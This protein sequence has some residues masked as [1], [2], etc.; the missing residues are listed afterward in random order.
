[1]QMYA[2]MKPRSNKDAAAN[3]R[4]ALN[5]LCGVVREHKKAGIKMAP[6]MLAVQVVA[7][8]LRAH[9]EAHGTDSLTP[10]R[11]DPLTHPIIC[12]ML[13]T[14]N[15]ASRGALVVNWLIYF[16]IAVCATISVLAETGMR[17]GD[18][19]KALASTKFTKGRLTFAKLV[20]SLHG[21]VTT[22]LTLADLHGI[23]EGDGCW[24][25]YG[26]LKNDA[27][28]EFFGSKPSWLPYSSAA[29]RNACRSLSNLEIAA[30]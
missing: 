8:M 30:A 23:T 13:R 11:K 25:E 19:S 9:V 28:A 24:L 21:L 26:V 20:W 15:G 3:P 7:G 27:F 12:G 18:V 6:L 2:D 22:A 5:K 1:M 14:A 4:S 17:K 16:W 29:T 10:S